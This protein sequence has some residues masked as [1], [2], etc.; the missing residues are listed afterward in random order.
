[1]CV[2]DLATKVPPYFARV[3]VQFVLHAA[4]RAAAG[5]K[6]EK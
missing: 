4:R 3:R 5:A 2:D 1:M 6:N